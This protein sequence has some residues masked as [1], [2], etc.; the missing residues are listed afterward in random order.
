MSG[1][2]DMGKVIVN[3]FI[4]CLKKTKQQVCAVG[5]FS[6]TPSAAGEWKGT[7]LSLVRNIA[8]F[9][10]SDLHRSMLCLPLLTLRTS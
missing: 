5:L 1:S 2:H 6:L 4:T 10:P 3:Y 7:G 9:F 8:A